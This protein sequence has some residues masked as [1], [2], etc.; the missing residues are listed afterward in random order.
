MDALDSEGYLLDVQRTFEKTCVCV[1][2]A[3]AELDPEED[4]DGWLVC[5]V[6]DAMNSLLRSD[7]E[8][9]RRGEMMD[10]WD[11][12]YEFLIHLCGLEPGMTLAA[13]VAYN[14]LPKPCRDAFYALI[15]HKRSFPDC[16]AERMG[17][18]EDLVVRT[19]TAFK[20]LYGLLPMDGSEDPGSNETPDE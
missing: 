11:A 6:I 1:A 12:R 18:Q 15:M 17:T 5:R 7:R 13:S 16:I 8:E 20:A 2:S 14:G 4:L 19:R 3:A 10:K 9:C